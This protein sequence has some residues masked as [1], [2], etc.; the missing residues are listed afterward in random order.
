MGFIDS[1][2]LLNSQSIQRGTTQGV[3]MGMRRGRA[4]YCFGGLDVSQSLTLDRG[5]PQTSKNRGLSENTRR[6]NMGEP[7]LSSSGSRGQRQCSAALMSDLRKMVEEDGGIEGTEGG[8]EKNG[9]RE[10]EK[11]GVGGESGREKTVKP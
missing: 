2:I 7:G 9:E 11:K 5:G 6:L 8:G 3:S 10:R 4:S 1:A